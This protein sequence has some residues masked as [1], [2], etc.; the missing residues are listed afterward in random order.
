MNTYDLNSYEK[1]YDDPRYWEDS[2]C[3]SEQQ[4]RQ[5]WSNCRTLTDRFYDEL[6]IRGYLVPKSHTQNQNS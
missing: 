1:T 6:V 2:F 4:R 3:D 5:N